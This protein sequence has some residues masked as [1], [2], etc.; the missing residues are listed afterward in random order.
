[1]GAATAGQAAAELYRHSNDKLGLHWVLFRY[2]LVLLALKRFDDCRAVI[3]EYLEVGQQL[4]LGHV[5]ALANQQLGYLAYLEGDLPEA[6]RRLGFRIEFALRCNDLRG[7]AVTLMIMVPV[8]ARL[9]LPQMAVRVAEAI[10]A[11]FCAV[12]LQPQPPISGI[13]G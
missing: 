9:G 10:L 5:F 13:A 6:Q 8:L 12:G 11:F 4:G 3:D 1:M 7:A 2:S